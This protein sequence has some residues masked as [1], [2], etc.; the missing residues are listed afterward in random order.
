MSF[1]A[2]IIFAVL[3]G[4]WAGRRGRNGII[5]TLAALLV[6]PVLAAIVLAVMK[7]LSIEQEL[8]RSRREN[9]ML[10]ERVAVSEADMHSRMDHIENRMDHLE[11]NE[12]GKIRQEKKREIEGSPSPRF[13][14]HCGNK[15]PDDSVFCPKCGS[16]L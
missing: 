5:W 4:I 12:P 8:E 9:G 3:V 13:C 15:V 10:K 7:D 6:S 11:G 14:K 16:R 2:Y 1:I